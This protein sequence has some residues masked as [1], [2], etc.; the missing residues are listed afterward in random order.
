MTGPRDSFGKC[1]CYAV[2]LTGFLSTVTLQANESAE[3]GK[4]AAVA[5]ALMT[6]NADAITRDQRD[7]RDRGDQDGTRPLTVTG[8]VPVRVNLNTFRNAAQSLAQVANDRR[9]VQRQIVSVPLV[10][11]STVN[12]IITGSQVTASGS[13][14]MSG[15]IQGYSTSTAD[16][17][18]TSAGV[19]TGA[20][21]FTTSN[22]ETQ[23]YRTRRRA[24]GVQV[25]EQFELDLSRSDDDAREILSATDVSVQR[26]LELARIQRSRTS[27]LT[28]STTQRSLAAADSATDS[29]VVDLMVMYS[30][31][32]IAQFGGLAATRSAIE[33]AVEKTNTGWRRSGIQTRLRLVHSTRLTGFPDDGTVDIQRIA[34]NGDGF[35]DYLH[36]LRNRVGADLVMV[37]GNSMR[38]PSGSSVCGLGYLPNSLDP[39]GDIVGFSYVA[40]DCVVGALTFSHEIGHNLGAHHDRATVGY[41]GRNFS[42]FG[43]ITPSLNY[44][45]V[46]AYSAPCGG[47]VCPRI[48]FW[49]NPNIRFNGEPL[50]VAA[51]S[52][53]SAFNVREVNRNSARVAR[54]REEVISE[55]PAI[56]SPRNQSWI[57]ARNAIV[58]FSANGTE[59]ISAWRVLAGSVNG[60][61]NYY[62]SG[63][64]AAGARQIKINRLPDDGTRVHVTLMYRVGANWRR[65]PHVLHSLASPAA[66]ILNEIQPLREYMEVLPSFI[67]SSSTDQAYL[68]NRLN[69]LERAVLTNNVDLMTAVELQIRRRVNGCGNSPDFDDYVFSCRAQEE[70]QVYT[71]SIIVA[72]RQL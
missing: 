3:K 47:A 62:D 70:I 22:G 64:I 63:V 31:Q 20:I 66:T 17:L 24:D 9:A 48:N 72:L 35:L 58:Y 1:L 33:F 4:Q 54:Y 44:R 50:G 51:P 55:K 42:N 36:P 57:D 2:L 23:S 12:V 30:P 19:L 6:E 34:G 52:T 39:S 71:R 29:G 43:Y 61:R 37:I 18:L 69:V 65:A 41:T 53:R 26:S 8:E 45:T 21:E 27:A 68:V 32:S 25:F 46:M 7:I 49:S 59:N 60:A 13:T 14:I 15:S 11:G 16:F 5:G 28:S 56:S 10:D 40:T 67:F 38:L